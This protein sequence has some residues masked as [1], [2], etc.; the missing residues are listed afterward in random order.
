LTD[1]LAE[2]PSHIECASIFNPAQNCERV[3]RLNASHRAGSKDGEHVE[4]Q[5]SEYLLAVT[6]RPAGFLMPV[7]LARDVLKGVISREPSRQLTGTTLM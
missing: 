5:P 7:P 2:P 1:G 6:R 4:L 3:Q